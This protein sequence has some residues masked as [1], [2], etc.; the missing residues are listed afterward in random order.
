M[1]SVAAYLLA[2]KKFSLPESAS[3]SPSE[4]TV[5]FPPAEAKSDADE[6]RVGQPQPETSSTGDPAERVTN[7]SM[8]VGLS[9]FLG[10]SAG[11]AVSWLINYLGFIFPR[12]SRV[13]EKLYPIPST[14]AESYLFMLGTLGALTGL[15][16]WILLEVRKTARRIRVLD[17]QEMIRDLVLLLMLFMYAGSIVGGSL[18][19]VLSLSPIMDQIFGLAFLSSLSF[20]GGLSLGLIAIR[21]S[22]GR[23]WD[24]SAPL[25]A[26]A[27]GFLVSLGL[28]SIV[29]V[30]YGLIPLLRR[31]TL[32]AGVG[33]AAGASVAGLVASLI[34]RSI[35]KPRS[36]LLIITE[37]RK[38]RQSTRGGEEYRGKVAG[39]IVSELPSV[40]RSAWNV[41]VQELAVGQPLRI[42]ATSS[43]AS[44]SSGA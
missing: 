39:I 10:F 24:A 15:L 27:A 12:L 20:L 35:R 17:W 22:R 34:L 13:I 25:V 5:D 1:L 8:R 11:T 18:T 2:R 32:S 38:R 30:V 41:A 14:A 19:G 43:L 9:T 31:S 6:T 40:L 23:E 26:A 37:R 44:E 3:K 29:G 16:L 7:E 4:T 36:P 28:L 42:L 33:A 21:L